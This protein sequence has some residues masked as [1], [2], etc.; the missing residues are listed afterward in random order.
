MKQIRSAV[1]GINR[2]EFRARAK[3]IWCEQASVRGFAR[4]AATFPRENATT[5]LKV[6]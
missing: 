1:A 2:I 4:A 6:N 5:E 3:V